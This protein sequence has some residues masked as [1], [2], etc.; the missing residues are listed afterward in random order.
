M[1][2]PSILS[3]IDHP[4]I[5]ARD[6]TAARAAYERLG[7]TVTPR[8]RHREWGT[9]NWCIMFEKDYLELRGFVDP[10]T[11]NPAHP[12]PDRDGLM[13]L[14]FDTADAE[15]SYAE[16]TR[17]GLHPQPVKRLTRDFE[18]SDGPVQP[19]FALCF[20]GAA[21]TPGLMSVVLCQ[22]LT[23]ALLRRPEWLRHTNGALG[24]RIVTGVVP[25]DVAATAKLHARLF[26][27]RAIT[28]ERDRLAICDG[29][30]QTIELLTPDVARET[31]AGTESP[32][33]DGTKGLL[34]ISL[35]VEDVDRTE[36]YLQTHGVR[37]QR[38]ASGSLCVASSETCGVPLEF[39]N[40]D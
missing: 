5:A 32:L 22:H 31:W 35:E 12:L 8:G 36:Q 25:E 28:H 24:V 16:L 30:R 20:L 34:S 39:M 13:G 11:Q 27:E 37:F 3:G 15:T 38:S 23:P 10:A 2:E 18:L 6:M 4:I 7:F 33:S 21:D 14:A 19:R 17:R 1:A 29:D 40:R 26:G 9:G